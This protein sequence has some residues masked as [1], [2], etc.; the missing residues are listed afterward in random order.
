MRITCFLGFPLPN[1]DFLVF[2]SRKLFSNGST[3][4]KGFHV[5]LPSTKC[6]SWCFPFNEYNFCVCCPLK[7][8]PGFSKDQ[9][10][11]WRPSKYRKLISSFLQTVE[12]AS[13]GRSSDLHTNSVSGNYFMVNL[14]TT[15]S[16]WRFV[17]REF[18]FS[19][20]FDRWQ[21]LPRVTPR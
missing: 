20:S 13:R 19:L 14:S 18:R 4:K 2:F 3:W 7:Y 8:F 12:N 15:V 6:V 16:P 9:N 17:R 5:V 21:M 11:F 1:F 10:S